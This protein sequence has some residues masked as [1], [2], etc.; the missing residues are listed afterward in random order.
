MIYQALFYGLLTAEIIYAVIWGSG[1][2]DYVLDNPVI[3][4][5]IPLLGIMMM[6]IIISLSFC[7]IVAAFDRRKHPV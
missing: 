1:K 4:T 6:M 7:T 3:T 2:F 5:F